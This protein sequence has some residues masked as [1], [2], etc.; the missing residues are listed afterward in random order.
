M[1][2]FIAIPD[3]D[4]RSARGPKCYITNLV[5]QDADPKRPQQQ[6]H[7]IDAFI[8]RGPQIEYEGF[9]D[10]RPSV[11]RDTAVEFLGMIDADEAERLRS[12]NVDLMVALVLAE[13]RA[14]T[15]QGRLED[16]ILANA[17]Q[18]VQIASLSDELGQAYEDLYAEDDDLAVDEADS[19]A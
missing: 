6:P 17:E 7:E 16:M 8:L 19:D 12:E 5:R 18:I 4:G 13:E 9:L 15:N 1:T 14:D 3:F 11:I 10:I 2:H